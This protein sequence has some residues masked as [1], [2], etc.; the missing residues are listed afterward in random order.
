MFQDTLYESS[1]KWYKEAI[2]YPMES[3]FTTHDNNCNI[4]YLHWK[5]NMKL[6][7]LKKDNLTPP[8]IVFVHG[9]S[10]H[11]H[12]FHHIGPLF[13]KSGYDVIALSLSGHG[14]SGTKEILGRDVWEHEIVAVCK[15]ATLFD[16]NRFSKPILVGHSLGS[17]VVE[18]TAHVYPNLF[19]GV[20]VLDGGVPHPLKWRSEAGIVLDS[21]RSFSSAKE[22][23]YS[24]ATIIPRDR[25][26][27]APPQQ[28]LPFIHE[29]IANNSIK[30]S[31]TKKDCW[32]WKFDPDAYSK[33]EFVDYCLNVGT[34]ELVQNLNCRVAIV[35]GENS[36]IVLKEAQDFMRYFLGTNIPVIA[37]PDA[38]HH[39][40]LDQP[41][42]VVAALRM[43][44]AEWNRSQTIN[45][46]GTDF[47]PRNNKKS[48][49]SNFDGDL[50]KLKQDAIDTQMKIFGQSGP[51]SSKKEG[52][53][54]KL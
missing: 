22:R 8:S 7:D 13:C 28:V 47:F 50:N 30:P 19:H 27:L 52:S 4:H 24:N 15:D 23:A 32:T 25:L 18:E 10:A 44:F 53:N 5:T 37:I 48:V 39:C 42:A 51:S 2:N 20:V 14:D 9:T 45:G 3:K 6:I 49:L 36:L 54:S 21:S 46:K 26:R 33:Y 34:P 41:L 12:W 17:F 43:C 35:H 38:G 11:A 1:P 31:T 29:H 40:F 16:E